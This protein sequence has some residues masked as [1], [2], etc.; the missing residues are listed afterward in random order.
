MALPPLR[1]IM[2]VMANAAQNASKRL[3]RD[4]NEVEQLQVSVKGPGD[5]V[6]QADIRAENRPCAR[7]STRPV[8]AMPS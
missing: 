4:F 2:T 8:P 1:R 7:N 3:L 5:F 6:C